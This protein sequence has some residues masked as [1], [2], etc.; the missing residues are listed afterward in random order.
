MVPWEFLQ[1]LVQGFLIATSPGSPLEIYPGIPVWISEI[2]AGISIRN[3]SGIHPDNT[4]LQY[5]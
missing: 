4:S 3:L 2:H 5:V 1:G